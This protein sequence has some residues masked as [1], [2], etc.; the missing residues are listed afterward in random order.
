MVLLNRYVAYGA[1]SMF[2]SLLHNVFLLYHV[3]VFVSLRHIDPTGF[4]C[5]ESMFLVYNSLND[6][7]AG[8]MSD[9]A[10]LEGILPSIPFNNGPGQKG[11]EE[12][13]TKATLQKRIR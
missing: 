10:L 2:K 6:F 13:V 9:S 1:A 3:E 12:R 5:C 4:W 8:G 11:R 7:I